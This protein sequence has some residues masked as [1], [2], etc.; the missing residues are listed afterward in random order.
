MDGR[1]GASHQWMA[2]C[3][4]M[5]H[6][7]DLWSR[8]CSGAN[9]TDP[10]VVFSQLTF[11]GPP[12]CVGQRSPDLL[13]EPQESDLYEQSVRGRKDSPIWYSTRLRISSPLLGTEIGHI[14]NSNLRSMLDPLFPTARLSR[15]SPAYSFTHRVL[16]PVFR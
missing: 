14:S 4:F 11:C 12:A 10:P 9:E 7:N 3:F 16:M 5:A 2:A 13:R 15:R 1:C 6:C 8:L